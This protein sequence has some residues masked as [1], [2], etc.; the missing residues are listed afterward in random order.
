M[1]LNEYT[2]AELVNM[3]K[4]PG[5]NRFN[6]RTT[7][8]PNEIKIDRVVIGKITAMNPNLDIYFSVRGYV[9][10]IRLVNCMMRL[11]VL[12]NQSKYR[13][14]K[15]KLIDLAIKQT[16]SKNDLLMNCTC[17]DF[18]Y[19]FSYAATVNHYGFNTN[20]SIPALIR[21][22]KNQ[23]SGC[24]HLIR[25]INAPYLWRP[26]VVTLVNQVLKNDPTILEGE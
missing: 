24:K 15:R 4:A 22:P 25:I 26:K 12:N 14:D 20:Q 2:K 16:L 9:C 21:N 8:E 1:I 5:F 18:Y 11:R 10:S 17:P 7:V 23:G 6:R 3:S 13:N 19:R